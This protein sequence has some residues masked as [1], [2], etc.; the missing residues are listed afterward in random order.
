H[1]ET[2][3]TYQTT[4]KSHLNETQ[5]WLGAD[6][7]TDLLLPLSNTLTSLN[8]TGSLWIDAWNGDRYTAAQGCLSLNVEAKTVSAFEDCDERERLPGL[9]RVVASEGADGVEPVVVEVAGVGDVVVKYGFVNDHITW[10]KYLNLTTPTNTTAD[11]LTT[12]DLPPPTE[13]PTSNTTDIKIT[14]IH[15]H[16]TRASL[17]HTNVLPI[18]RALESANISGTMWIGSWNGDDYGA[19][20]CLIFS[21]PL[22]VGVG[23]RCDGMEMYP[24]LVEL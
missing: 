18:S 13:T 2:W 16:L 15:R 6:I 23:T 24:Y 5:T 9:R 14:S 22:F 4:L 10:L 7:T 19:K 1:P 3:S 12:T 20:T 11:T 8:I 21:V 17:N